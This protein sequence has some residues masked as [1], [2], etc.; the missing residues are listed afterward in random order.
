VVGRIA[1]LDRVL[2]VWIFAAI[3]LGLALGALVPGLPGA[4]DALQVAD[5]SLPIAVGL[6]YVALWLGRRLSSR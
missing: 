6:V 2:P 4:L 5:V 3:G 1:L